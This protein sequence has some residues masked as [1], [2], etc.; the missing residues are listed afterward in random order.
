[1]WALFAALIVYVVAVLPTE[2]KIALGFLA[3]GWALW[4]FN[5]E[6]FE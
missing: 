6:E 1:M 4:Q 2:S 3:F 5:L